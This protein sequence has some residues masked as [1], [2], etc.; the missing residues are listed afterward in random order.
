ML[1]KCFINNLLI[2]KDLLT[3]DL[4]QKQQPL[5]VWLTLT[6]ALTD[7]ESAVAYNNTSTLCIRF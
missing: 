5:N 2:V 4:K 6:Y 3:A 1:K 7:G